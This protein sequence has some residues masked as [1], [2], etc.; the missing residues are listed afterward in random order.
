MEGAGRS[1]Y[2]LARS[3]RERKKSVKGK[4]QVSAEKSLKHI[5]PCIA[6]AADERAAGDLMPQHPTLDVLDQRSR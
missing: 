5:P 2:R 4:G 6:I 3:S 1:C